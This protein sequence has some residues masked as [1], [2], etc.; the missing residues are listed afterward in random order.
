MLGVATY[1]EDDPADDFL[2]EYAEEIGVEGTYAK[3]RVGVFLGEPGKTVKDPFFGGEGPDRTGCLRCG[4][5]M[6]GCPHG[7]KNT[8]VKNYLWFAERAG[9]QIMPERTV[10]DIR[11]HGGGYAVTAPRSR[12][13]LRRVVRRER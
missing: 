3:T 1:D 4:R 5:C 7:A 8:L 12:R 9:V 10:L 6:V 11:P 2:R 13:A